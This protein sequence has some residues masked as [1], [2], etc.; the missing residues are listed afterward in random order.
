MSACCF[1]GHRELPKDQIDRIWSELMSSVEALVLAG[2]EEFR[3]GGALGVDTLAALAV[4]RLKEK[5]PHIRLVL[6]LPCADQDKNWSDTSRRRY[7]EIKLAADEVN[8]LAQH[9]YRG[10]MFVRNRALVD[11]SEYCIAYLCRPSGGAR[12][13]VDYATKQGLKIKN[14]GE[15]L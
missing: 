8:V 14:L 15:I 2:V 6:M 10:C 7:E 12:M 9:Y 5:Y 4:L 3:A 1:T 13:T 11:G